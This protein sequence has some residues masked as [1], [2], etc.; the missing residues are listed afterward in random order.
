MASYNKVILL[1]NLTRDPQ[2]SYL[3]SKMPVCEFGFAVNNK[4][5]GK[6]GQAK[7]SVLFIDCRSFG[8]QAETLNTHVHKGDPLLI[9][10]RLDLDTWEKDGQKHSKHRV[11][12]ERFQFLGGKP[13]AEPKPEPAPEPDDAGSQEDIPF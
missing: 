6:D 11:T 1:G 5:K 9:E 2:L 10:G 13:K 7:E 8:K 12:V 4:W 3:P